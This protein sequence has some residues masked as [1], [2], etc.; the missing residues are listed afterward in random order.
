LGGWFAFRTSRSFQLGSG[1]NETAHKHAYSLYKRWFL[2]AQ[3][4]LLSDTRRPLSF[5]TFGNSRSLL[6]FFAFRIRRS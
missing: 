5:P 3:K 4:Q 6:A 2:L 1:R